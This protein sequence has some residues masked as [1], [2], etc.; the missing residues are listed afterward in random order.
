MSST[1]Y[2]FVAAVGLTILA[3]NASAV[4]QG[5]GGM[6]NMDGMKMDSMESKGKNDSSSNAAVNEGEVKA[7]DKAKKNITLKHGPVKSKTV[8]MSPMTMT[9]PVKNAS[10]LSNVKVGDKVNFNIDNVE[11]TATV[12][13][14]QV[15]K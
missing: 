2:K 12:T 8:E 15:K 10:L 13:S 4:D 1:F 11:N 9:F 5:K 7:V 3:L 14:L 6:G